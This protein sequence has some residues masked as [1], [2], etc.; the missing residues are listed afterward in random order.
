MNGADEGQLCAT[1]LQSLT[2]GVRRVYQ[3]P[4]YNWAKYVVIKQIQLSRF[5]SIC[6]LEVYGN[7]KLHFG[8]I[9]I[10]FSLVTI[11]ISPW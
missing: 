3:C 1:E 2:K 5:L 9:E 10:N 7:G 6:E 11:L 4:S 8:V